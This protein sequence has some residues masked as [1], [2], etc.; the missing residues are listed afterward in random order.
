VRILLIAPNQPDIN[1][2]PEIRALSDTHQTTVLNGHVSSQDIY[3]YIKNRAYDII[4]FA[5]HQAADENTY[6]KILLSGGETLDLAG[7]THIVKLASASLV[8]FNLCNASRFAAYLVRH[9]VP[10][11]IYTTIALKDSV[12]WQTPWHFY[13]EVRRQEAVSKPVEF[14]RIF[15]LTDPG[16][17]VYG[18]NSGIDYYLGAVESIQTTLKA[19]TDAE[20]QTKITV[21]A[22]AAKVEQHGQKIDLQQSQLTGE[23]TPNSLSTMQE[24]M[25][26]YFTLGI[27]AAGILSF[28]IPV[29]QWF[30]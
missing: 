6:D 30:F 7:V 15:D 4:H 1:A 23:R 29:I 28:L 18:W 11:C 26:Q 13:E 19:L 21:T 27:M 2:I 14:R 8:F 3:S 9:G 10:A 17:G 24:N 25:I 16:D 20:R 22:L 5:T 12:A